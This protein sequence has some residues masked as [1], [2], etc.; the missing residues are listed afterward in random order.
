MA[1]ALL[2]AFALFAA[3]PD[4][5]VTTQQAPAAT[6]D[7]PA[8]PGEPASEYE[9]VAWCYGALGAHMGLHDVAMPEVTRIEKQFERIPGAGKADL[10]SYDRQQEDGKKQLAL[11]REA[12]TAAEKASIKPIQQQGLAAIRK[13]E[14]VWSGAQMA[15]PKFLAREWMSWELPERCTT[16]ATGLEQ[17]AALMGQALSYNQ[18]EPAPEAAEPAPEPETAPVAETPAP[19]AEDAISDAIVASEPPVTD[20]EDT[21]PAAPVENDDTPVSP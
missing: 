14:S 20:D 10:T 2:L 1:P 17:K 11:F 7:R 21:P 12:M 15:D 6:P 18:A 8:S 13:G 4:T 9:L 19:P 5:A 16:T 3:D